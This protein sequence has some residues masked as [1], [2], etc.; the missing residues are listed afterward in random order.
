ME[1]RCDDRAVSRTNIDFYS[2]TGREYL[3]NLPQQ[4]VFMLFRTKTLITLSLI[5][6]SSCCEEA[7]YL[8]ANC[9]SISTMIV[10]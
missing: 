8:T 9:S 2:I 4:G 1:F 5:L 7:H 6:G 3:T 10:V